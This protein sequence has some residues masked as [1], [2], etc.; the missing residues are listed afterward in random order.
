M[1][2]AN[3]G[4]WDKYLRI[5]IGVVLIG[6]MALGYIGLWGW[7]GVVPILSAVFNYCPLY[8]LIG[9]STRH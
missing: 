8:Q 1:I 5:V 7:I 2:Q 6:L 3:V 4:G 9:F